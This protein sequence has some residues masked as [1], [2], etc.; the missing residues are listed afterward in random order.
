MQIDQLMKLDQFQVLRYDFLNY[1]LEELIYQ[2]VEQRQFI[3]LF[4]DPYQTK[5]IISKYPHPKIAL[6][7]TN[8][9]AS[10]YRFGLVHEQNL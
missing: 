7:P 9:I 5:H 8:P 2:S 6:P 10:Q 1:P 4:I 3:W